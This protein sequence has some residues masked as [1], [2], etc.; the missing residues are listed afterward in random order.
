MCSSTD[1]MNPSFP[2]KIC[3]RV[4][5]W[6]LRLTC[7]EKPQLQE[8]SAGSDWPEVWHS[9]RGDGGWRGWGDGMGGEIDANHLSWGWEQGTRVKEADGRMYSVTSV[10][11]P[12]P[13]FLELER[14]PNPAVAEKSV[15]VVHLQAW[16]SERHF[17]WPLA[18][19][20]TSANWLSN[21]KTYL[22]EGVVSLLIYNWKTKTKRLWTKPWCNHS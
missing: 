2:F 22:K 19:K 3:E 5:H 6:A 12:V 7:G 4:V 13:F 17:L 21:S 20:Y 9:S 8:A 1:S 10:C 14:N 15:L 18:A 16:V 11:L